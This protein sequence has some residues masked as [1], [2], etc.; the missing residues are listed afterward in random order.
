VREA[1]LAA[2]SCSCRMDEGGAE[3]D[4]GVDDSDGV[5]VEDVAGM[6]SS[7]SLF[8]SVRRRHASSTA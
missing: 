3:V 8:T 2:H 6:S 5:D 1:F 4:A 7:R